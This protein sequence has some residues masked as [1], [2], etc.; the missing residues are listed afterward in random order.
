[1][2]SQELHRTQAQVESW[3]LFLLVSEGPTSGS[4]QT[5]HTAQHRPV[6]ANPVLEEW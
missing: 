1:M 2:S 3:E 6:H 4:M 5:T